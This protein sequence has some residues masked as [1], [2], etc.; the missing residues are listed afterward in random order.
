MSDQEELG[1]EGKSER[2]EATGDHPNAAAEGE[3]PEAAPPGKG[4][5]VRALLLVLLLAVLAGGG[6]GY[7]TLS[8]WAPS[9]AAPAVAKKQRF[10]IPPKP[11]PRPLPQKSGTLSGGAAAPAPPPKTPPKAKVAVVPAAPQ[12][13][14]VAPKPAKAATPAAHQALP[15][16]SA[17]R[18][19]LEGGAFLFSS[20]LAQAQKAVRRLGFEPR[21]TTF[22]RREPMVRLRLG[23]FSPQQARAKVS[24]LASLA[25]DAFCLRQGDRVT[26]FAA[27]YFSHRNARRF[28]DRLEKQG[29]RVSEVMVRVPMTLTSLSFGRFESVEKA[30]KAA[31][32]AKKKG[33]DVYVRRIR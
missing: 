6:Y 13:S 4:R 27:S 18:Y 28:E 32:L 14:T 12:P 11:Q 20:D 33:L 30:N 21:R 15:R 9:S 17:G 22:Q 5:R 16:R 19:T 10:P 1:F 3:T 8:S 24:A 7:F 23:T 31:V 26:V 2:I 25:P 29:I